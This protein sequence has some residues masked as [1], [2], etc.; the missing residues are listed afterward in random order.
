MNEDDSPCFLTVE[1]VGL[2]APHSGCN[3]CYLLSPSQK[4]V[5]GSCV[6]GLGWATTTSSH[7]VAM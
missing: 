1:E 5:C 7:C 3:E 4:Y 2:A 6:G